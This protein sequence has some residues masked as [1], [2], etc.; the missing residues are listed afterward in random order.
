MTLN[1]HQQFYEII[2]S[3]K[4]PL[5]LFSKQATGDTISSS[6]AMAELFS[7]LGKSAEII[8][9]DFEFPKSYQFFNSK[10]KI[11]QKLDDHKKFQLVFDVSNIDNPNVEHEIKNQR[12]HININSQK[13]HINKD[14]LIT[15]KQEYKHDL[16]ITINTPDLESLDYIY[17]ENPDL[18]YQV[19]IV[20][21]D[22]ST[23]NEHYG[24]LNLINIKASSVS[25][26]L[27]D[28]ITQIDDKLLDEDI[29]TYLLTGMI[30]K[31]NSFKTANIT[32]QSLQIASEL[33][34]AG[35]QRENI[36]Q[37]L[38]QTKSVDTIK[39]WG[40]VLTKL[41]LNNNEKM[42]W[43]VIKEED[44]KKTNTTSADLYGIIDEL[45]TNIPT[46]EMTT[47]FFA[48]NNTVK[49]L[50]KSEKE[51]DLVSLFP[52]NIPEVTNKSLV[53]IKVITKP[54]EILKKLNQYT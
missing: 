43:A 3:S 24:Q 13:G 9:P 36:I 33:I 46:I 15:Q 5:I 49:A 16:I 26:M 22:H 1:Q 27:H 25:E 18:F 23:E 29:A 19:P 41:Q 44:F 12:L 48:E 50:I 28:L 4:N 14:H 31:T 39:L 11:L 40:K 30:E 2:T 7:R 6:L 32:P 45:I 21:I 20:N 52:Q 38:Y 42:A 17:Q 10:H 34:A 8:S 37:N 47:I 51:L 53:K 54:S 35:A